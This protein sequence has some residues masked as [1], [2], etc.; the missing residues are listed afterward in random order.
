MLQIFKILWTL[1]FI[2]GQTISSTVKLK[3][4]LIYK[5]EGVAQINQD[6]LTF[7]RQVD[8]S[9][10]QSV[11]QRLKDSTTLYKEYCSLLTSYNKKGPKTLS[12]DAYVKASSLNITV[13]YI[14]TPLKYPLK[15]T[16]SV[17]ARLNAKKVEIRDLATYNA[18]RNYASERQIQQ[19]E[20][21]IKFNQQSNRFQ[22]ISDSQPA[23]LPK[24][25]S[26]IVYGG[27]YTGANHLADWE[28][29]TYVVSEALKYPFVYSQPTGNFV[30]RMAD[31]NDRDRLDYIMCEQPVA[32]PP[33]DTTPKNP[34]IE[35]AAHSCRRD[36]TALQAQTDYTISE[37]TSITNLNFT[38]SEE[39][40]W[41]SFFPQFE[42][43]DNQ[44]QTQTFWY[45][46]ANRNV[47]RPNIAPNSNL[48]TIT[49]IQAEKRIVQ[50]DF[51]TFSGLQCSIT[52]EAGLLLD[53]FKNYICPR[54]F[55]LLQISL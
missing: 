42:P 45:N 16:T 53:S 48:I 37:I 51:S 22:F 13:Q 43:L 20:A 54:C 38:L 47:P 6:Y 14:S 52:P 25:F 17:C 31:S 5:H 55:K 39:P 27:Y 18:A 41:T 2:I 30:L 21:G 44:E 35:I 24:L 32:K 11:A 40:V 33:P 7:K 9:A 36:Y 26:H 15:D 29:D 34:F 3:G 23:R 50:T 28:K 10:L 19:F 8:T 46:I 1:F 4:G 49:N 12:Q